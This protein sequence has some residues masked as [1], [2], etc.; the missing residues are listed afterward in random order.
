MT[1]PAGTLAVHSAA[2]VTV[3]MCLTVKSGV[4]V[5]LAHLES[6]KSSTNFEYATRKHKLQ[7]QHGQEVTRSSTTIQAEE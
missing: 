1:V 6:S 4:L 2:R 3:T 5:E 7:S